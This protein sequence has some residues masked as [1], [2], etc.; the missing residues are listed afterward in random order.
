[1]AGRKEAKTV[2]PQGKIEAFIGV[3]T[4][5]STKKATIEEI[6]KAVADGWACGSFDKDGPSTNGTKRSKSKRVPKA[7]I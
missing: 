6:N 4:G 1:M 5:K 2:R 7:R 3:L